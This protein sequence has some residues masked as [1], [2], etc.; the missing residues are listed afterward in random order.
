MNDLKGKAGA[1]LAGLVLILWLAGMGMVLMG[2]I[3]GTFL[4]LALMGTV[5][6]L[7]GFWKFACSKVGKP[8][9]IILTAVLAH[10]VFGIH[11]PV[12]MIALSWSL[13]LKVMV[14]EAH[15]KALQAS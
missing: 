12:S 14:I 5:E 13:I 8:I 11:G 2:V 1:A 15:S 6:R 9:V 4:V 3:G 10:A 7:P